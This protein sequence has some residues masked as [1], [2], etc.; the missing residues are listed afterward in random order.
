MEIPS[1][2]TL[3]HCCHGDGHITADSV[4][5]TSVGEEVPLYSTPSNTTQSVTQTPN[6]SYESEMEHG[7]LIYP[8]FGGTFY[9]D[10]LQCFI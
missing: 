4:L 10:Q 2:V 8:S 3:I 6:C 5:R 9:L 1:Q 7:T